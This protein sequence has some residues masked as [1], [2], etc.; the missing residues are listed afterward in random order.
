MKTKTAALPK[1]MRDSMLYSAMGPKSICTCGHTGDGAKAQHTGFGG[2]GACFATP[3]DGR[4][5][6]KC[7]QF[8]WKGWTEE[9]KR[10]M[11]EKGH[12]VK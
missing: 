8:S 7:G 6:C 4:N 1:R 12:E 11:A 10:W 5:E 9:Y 3:L 2:H